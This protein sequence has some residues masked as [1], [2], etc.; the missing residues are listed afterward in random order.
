[1]QIVIVNG[2]VIGP[3]PMPGSI[4]GIPQQTTDHEPARGE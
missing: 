2:K 4:P 3:E 1:L